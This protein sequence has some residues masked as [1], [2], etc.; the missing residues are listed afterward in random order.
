MAITSRSSSRNAKWKAR[1]AWA[2]ARCRLEN[3]GTVENAYI[4]L[5]SLAKPVFDFGA[6]LVA[7]Q[8]IACEERLRV[9][10]TGARE[11][12]DVLADLRAPV[13]LSAEG[14]RPALGCGLWFADEPRIGQIFGDGKGLR[15]HLAVTATCKT[16]G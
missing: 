5:V 14:K 9:S 3:P 16:G 6:D 11:L 15:V 12:R 10:T 13:F 8:L 2:E 4:E 1:S 7:D